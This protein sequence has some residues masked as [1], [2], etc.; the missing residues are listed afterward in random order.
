MAKQVSDSLF[1]SGKHL[2]SRCVRQNVSDILNIT[3][4]YVGMIVYITSEDKYYK[5]DAVEF[6][7]PTSYSEFNTS[8]SAYKPSGSKTISDLTSALLIEGNLGNIYNITDSG[9]TNEY[10]VEGTG[11]PIA[12]GANV[13][14]VDVGTSETPNYKFDLVGGFIDLSHYQQKITPSNKLSADLIKDGEV[15]VVVTQNEKDAWNNPLAKVMFTGTNGTTGFPAVDNPE[16][17]VI[18]ACLKLAQGQ[19]VNSAYNFYTYKEGNWQNISQGPRGDGNFTFIKYSENQPTQDTDVKD[20]FS[21]T[22]KYIGFYNGTSDSAPSDHQEYTWC[23]FMGTSPEVI[24]EPITGGTKVTITDE[25]NGQRSFNVLNGVDAVNPF[26]GIYG[27]DNKPTGTFASGDYIYAPTSASGET[28]NTIWK[29][30]GTT[31]QDSGETPDLANGETFA[32][33]ETLHKVAIDK[34][35]L[36]NPVNTA[37]PTKPVLANAK[38]VMQLKTKLQGVTAE[39]IKVVLSENTNYHIGKYVT[40]DGKISNGTIPL[41]GTPNCI[42]VVSCEGYDSIRWLGFRKNGNNSAGVAYGFSEN[43]ID[44]TNT[45]DVQLSEVYEYPNGAESDKAENMTIKVPSGAKYFVCTIRTYGTAETCVMTINDFYCYLQ[46]GKTVGDYVLGKMGWHGV[47]EEKDIESSQNTSKQAYLVASYGYAFGSG[48]KIYSVKTGNTKKIKIQANSEKSSYVFISK[49]DLPNSNIAIDVLNSN[50]AASCMAEYKAADDYRII[51]K[52]NEELEINLSEDAEYVWVQKQF[53]NLSG[54]LPS[55]LYFEIQTLGKDLDERVDDLEAGAKEMDGRV[56]ALENGVTELKSNGLSLT[57]GNIANDGS[58]TQSTTRLVTSPIE[59]SRGFY[60]EPKTGYDIVRVAMYDVYGNVVNSNVRNFTTGLPGSGQITNQFFATNVCV[61]G[62]FVRICLEDI[63]STGSLDC[64]K[65]F[66][67]MDDSRL[68]RMMPIGNTLDF[69]EFRYRVT[70]MTYPVWTALGKIRCSYSDNEGNNA[71]AQSLWFLEGQKNIGIPYS[72]VDQYSK[73]VGIDISFRTYFTALLNKRSLQ[74]T[75][76]VRGG[77]NSSKYGITYNLGGSGHS[78]PFYGTVCTGLTSYVAGLNRK[79]QAQIFWNS[80]D[81]GSGMR[82]IARKFTGENGDI[83]QVRPVGDTNWIDSD[84]QGLI[85]ILQ[86]MDFILTN[87]HCSVISD[88]FLNEYGTKTYIVWTEE[89]GP[90]SKS[91]PFNIERFIKRLQV[92]TQTVTDGASAVILRPVGLEYQNQPEDT[93]ASITKDWRDYPKELTIDP[94]ICT[95]AGDYASFPILESQYQGQVVEVDN[96]NGVNL[97]KAILNIHRGGSKYTKVQI[98]NE[99]ADIEQDAAIRD[100]LIAD[101]NAWISQSTIYPED[102]STEEDWV[103]LDLKAIDNTLVAGQYKARLSN[104]DGSVVSGFTHFEMVDINFGLYVD[105][106]N[107]NKLTASFSSTNGIPYLLELEEIN[108]MD[109]EG[110]HTDIDSIDV[111]NGKKVISWQGKV[112]TTRRYI[113]LFIRGAYNSVVMR[114]DAYNVLYS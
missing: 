60:F 8:S 68:T 40:A 104:S 55:H 51:I 73:F 25:A 67:Y 6:T 54:F 98:F 93:S 80:Q 92:N 14:I 41:N 18:Y 50:Y 110:Y 56:D 45:T 70:Q 53:I 23:K 65:E 28:G 113:K 3:D 72:G 64:I 88:I 29:W 39:E 91:T 33:S 87:G 106:N 90:I 114:I 49:L 112:N 10:F 21:P 76:N 86:P 32:S 83:V 5:V 75:E 101:G 52:K 100:I 77:D 82:Q 102:A 46:S 96:G 78:G 66:C 27:S 69:N 103:L 95:F 15:N 13:V 97:S 26:K 47:Y 30:N 19:G 22:Y 4:A 94:E 44:I 38:D 7:M 43:E 31:W 16:A 58:I 89:I 12:V 74:Y 9:S 62:F 63:N 34:S 11:H 71:I 109:I 59:I 20:N 61:P 37:D 85:D 35:H 36:V 107:E 99:N 2:D 57:F 17:N 111:E 1:A 48:A 84:Y 42:L 105:T 24:V 79:V 81:Q 108:G